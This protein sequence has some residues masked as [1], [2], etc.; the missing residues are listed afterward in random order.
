MQKICEPIKEHYEKELFRYFSLL[1][2]FKE[3][4][5]ARKYSFYRFET[6]EGCCKSSWTGIPYCADMVTLILHPMLITDSEVTDI[7]SFL[8]LDEQVYA[9]LKDVLIDDL[10][11]SYHIL[12]DATNYKNLVT[13]LEVLFLRGEH[14][15]KKEMLAKRI[16][17]LLGNSDIDIQC[18]YSK[19][20]NIYV[21]RSDAV[22][23]GVTT[24]ITRNSL[25][26]L[27]NLIRD[28]GRKYITHIQSELVQKPNLTFA[29][30]K[31]TLVD[32][33][34]LLVVQKITDGVLPQ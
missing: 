13:V 20:K 6:Q 29:E 33:L 28:I 14:G 12:D 7:N 27:R 26:E 21:D 2:F 1:H 18:L 34:I 19:V 30:A 8:T 16:A 23:D 24:N 31:D 32:K 3:G 5:I 17:L 11:Y 9:L 15:K 4:E 22:H 25:D 10:E